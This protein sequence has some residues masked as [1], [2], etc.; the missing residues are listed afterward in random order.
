MSDSRLTAF[1][2]HSGGNSIL[3]SM[4]YGKPLICAPIG[5]DQPGAAY[6]VDRMKLGVNLN[7]EVTGDTVI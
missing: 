1:V 6:R 7:M 4:Y 5:G 2:S 3:E